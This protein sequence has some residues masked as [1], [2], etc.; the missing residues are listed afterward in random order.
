[1]SEKQTVKNNFSLGEI[2]KERLLKF[3]NEDLGSSNIK[4]QIVDG[5]WVHTFNC[6]EDLH[7]CGA[8]VTFEDYTFECVDSYGGEGRGEE[9]YFTF[10]V[11]NNSTGDVDSYWTYDGWYASYQGS[12]FTD[13]NQVTPSTVTV[14]RYVP[15]NQSSENSI[16]T[17]NNY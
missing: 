1:M 3:F 2:T 9:Y 15:A 12:E 4:L 10:K 16:D 8:I 14:T 7:N 17:E 13:L 11:T 5:T 6:T